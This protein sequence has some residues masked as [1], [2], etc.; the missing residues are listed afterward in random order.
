[1]NLNELTAVSPI[2]GRYRSK[3]K[4]LAPYF[5]EFALIRYRVWVEVEYFIYLNE[6]G[7]KPLSPLSTAQVDGSKGALPQL[8]GRRCTRS[9]DHR[10][11]HKSRCKGS[12]V[13]H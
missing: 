11:N 13:F 7:L 1:M 6:T 2:D 3:L 10:T 8:Y 4:E 12:R 9:K 5:S